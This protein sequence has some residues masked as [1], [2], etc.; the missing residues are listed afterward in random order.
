MRPLRFFWHVFILLVLFVLI[1]SSLFGV[2]L[3]RQLSASMQTSIRAD[4]RKEAETLANV[5]KIS[6]DILQDPHRLLAAV[7][8]EDRLTIISPDGTVL[9][10]NWAEFL[11]KEHLENHATRPEI[12]SALN[13]TPAFS[14]RYSNTV[15]KQMLYYA[16]PLVQ[17]GKTVGVLRLSF[18]LTTVQQRLAELR[19]YLIVAALLS[20]LLSLPFAYLLSSEGT[21]QITRL[22]IASHRLA[23]GELDV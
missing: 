4:L 15:N 20:I 16:L 6:P 5:V 23:E 14:E 7:H 18:A 21:R 3:Y 1:A 22:R 8:T 11:G 12:Q 2:V 10:D 17:D 19:G 13:G 9:A